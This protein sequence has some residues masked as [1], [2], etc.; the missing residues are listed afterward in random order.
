MTD[1]VE[2]LS[3]LSPEE[4]RALLGRLLRQRA[5]RNE[6]FYPLSHVQRTM[7]IQGQLQAEIAVF[8]VPFAAR[9]RTEMDEA[10]LHRAIAALMDR[11]SVL[12]TTYETQQGQPVQ[13]VH[14]SLAVPLQIWEAAAWSEAELNQRMNEEFHRPFDLQRGPVFRVA[15][16]RR[17]AREH[18]LLLTVH[19]IAVDFWSLEILVDELRSL[20][21]AEKR[22]RP[23]T[24]TPAGRQ[25]TDFVAW[26]AELTA[27][28]EGERLWLYWKEKLAGEL[29]VLELPTDRPRPHLRTFGGATHRFNLDAG[30]Y[31]RVK[32][33]AAGRGATPYVSFLAAFQ[34]LLGRMT[35]QEHFLIGAPTSG[36]NR[37]EF[38]GTVGCLADGV[39]VRADLTG[40]PTFAD[41]LGRVRE[42]VL[43]A[44][45]HQDF[46]SALLVERLHAP[47]DPS[48]SQITQV[49]FGW[50]KPMRLEFQANGADDWLPLEGLLQ[51]TLALRY[52]V[53]LA[54]LMVI[55]LETGTSLSFLYQY[56]TDLF[57]ADTI[58]RMAEH[59]QVLLEAI[60]ADP[61]QRIGQLPILTRTEEQQLL[62]DWNAT[63]TD[64]PE[65]RCVHQLIEDQT[66]RT[67]DS[68][69]VVHGDR[70]LTYRELDEAANCF[71]R[72]LASL[73]VGPEVLA[74]ICVERS[75]EMVIGLLAILKA[76]GAYVPLDPGSPPERL[77]FMIE[78]ARLPVVLTAQHLAGKLPQQSVRLV[79]LDKT[80]EFADQNGKTP[81]S[82]VRPHN[83][84][85]V[86]YTS[87]STGQPK[88]VLIEHRSAV[89]LITS[90]VHSY[91]PGPDDRIL[92]QTALSFDVSVGEI[93]PMLTVGGTVVLLDAAGSQDIDG[94]VACIARHRVTILGAVPS[95]L[96][97]LNE[98]KAEVPSIRLVLSGAEALTFGDIDHLADFAVVTNGYG[99]TET[100]VCATFYR[101]PQ[102]RSSVPRNRVPIGRPI[103]NT[104]IYIL[105]K[106][107][108]PVPIGVA[109]EL[110]IGG[111]GV[112][113]GYLNQPELTAQRF[114]ANPF[115]RTPGARLYKSGD[116]ARYLSDG[117]IEFLGRMDQQ[118]KVRGFRIELGE[119]EAA[120]GKHPGIRQVVVTVGNDGPGGPRLLAYFAP[121]PGQTVIPGELRSFLRGKLPYYMVPSAFVLLE[122]FPLTAGGKVD[123]RAL[124]P[125]GAERETAYVAP[126]TP[127]EEL[128]AEVWSEVLHVDRIGI[129]DDFLELGGHSLLAVQVVSR[130]RDMFHV[131]LPL[132]TL[133][134]A[135][136]TAHLAAYIES[137]VQTR[138][139]KPT[140]LIVPLADRSQA[141]LSF[142]QQLIWML[143][144]LTPGGMALHIPTAVR[145]KGRL[146]VPIL[147]RALNEVV[148]RHEALRTTFAVVEGAPVQTVHAGQVVSLPIEELGK[149]GGVEQESEL[150]RRMA[151][152][153]ILPFDLSRGPL[154][155]ACV[156]RLGNDHHV[157]L[158]IVHHLVVDGWS[159]VILVRE[160]L[161]LYQSFLAGRP[162]PLPELPIQ[163]VDYCH[164]QRR[165]LQDEM[166]ATHL[167]YWRRQLSDRPPVLRLPSDRAR[168][169]VQTYRGNRHMMFV[170]TALAEQLRALSRCEGATLFM[171]LLAAFKV[172][173]YRHTGQDNILAG[174]PVAGRT[175]RE[176]EGLIGVF[177]NT[178]VLRTDL[179]GDPT[180]RELLGR[181]RQ[182]TLDAHAHQDLPYEVLLRE[183]GPRIGLNAAPL[184]Q[185]M[186]SYQV[187]PAPVPSLPGGLTV[188]ALDIDYPVELFDLT[189]TLNDTD[190]GLTC[191]WSY[192][193]ALFEPEAIQDLAQHFEILLGSILANPDMPISKLA[194][195]T[196][197]ERR[198]LL[199]DWNNTQ[200]DLGSPACIHEVFEAQ[201]VKAPDAVALSVGERQLTYRELNE[202]AN[203]LAHYLCELGVRPDVPVGVMLERSLDTVVAMLGVLKAGGAYLTLDPAWP[204][205][206]I[207]LILADSRAVLV[208]TRDSSSSSHLAAQVVH[209]D[210][211]PFSGDR[212]NLS[213]CAVPSNFAYIMY[214]SGSTGMPKGVMVAHS[215]VVNLCRA[216]A[217]PYQ[218]T[219][220]DRVLQFSSLSFDISVEEIFSTLLNGGTLVIQSHKEVPSAAELERLIERERLTI[221]NLPTAYWHEWAQ[222]RAHGDTPLP[223]SLRLVVV[224]GEAASSRHLEAWR[225]TSRHCAW[226]NT[227]GPTEATVTTTCY[228]P[229]NSCDKECIPLGRPLANVQTYVLDQHLAPVPIGAPGELY[230]GGAGVAR[231]YLNQPELTAE[232][233]L[234]DPFRSEP[235]ARLFKT[236]DMARHRRDGVLEFLGRA[237]QQIK[238]RGFRVEPGEI[239]AVLA[240]HPVVRE[241]VVD[242]R[243]H[244]PGDH[245]LIAY[246]VAKPGYALDPQDLRA[247]MRQTL[248]DFMVPAG[249]VPLAELPMTANGK[250]DRRELRTPDVMVVRPQEMVL[251]R[252]PVERRLAELFAGVLGLD[253]VSIHDSFFDLGGH[254]LLA[255]RLIYEIERAYDVHLPLAALFAAP[256]IAGLASLVAHGK[257]A[258]SPLVLL[259]DGGEEW[260]LFCIHP[261]G[262]QVRSYLPLTT[263]LSPAQP[264]YGIQSRVLTGLDQEHESIAS[265]A[266]DYASLI[267]DRQPTGPVRLLGH[268]LGGVVSVAVAALLEQLGRTVQF[269]ALLD[270]Y[271][272]GSEPTRLTFE[273]LTQLLGQLSTGVLGPSFVPL[274][275]AFAAL[276]SADQQ[277]LL[278]ELADR[279]PREGLELIVE[280]MAKT[281]FGL[282]EKAFRQHLELFAVHETLL[283]GYEP[284]MIRAP[285]FS[286]RALEP[287]A[288]HVQVPTD[289]SKYTTGEVIEEALPCNHFTIVQPPAIEVIA[290]RLADLLASDNY[291]ADFAKR[292]MP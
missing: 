146:D 216:V 134:E 292:G 64:F 219:A 172:L 45:T 129:H 170:P 132:Q 55:V 154:L 113:R 266:D 276:S 290:R 155:R 104:S 52:P 108:Q 277:R 87:G 245:R 223:R 152:W 20:Y 54:D 119:V 182:C 58:A 121:H 15:L 124:P 274:G 47:W 239:E 205:E 2:A 33:L 271:L 227:Y 39:V 95:L 107:L 106:H 42:T 67:P 37:A 12:R 270:A 257:P 159:I 84:A 10:A 125:A 69:A 244:T 195:I 112:A 180:F 46:P 1:Q 224:G 263:L 38:A 241:S 92:Q 130:L 93:F 291:V 26:Q 169:A 4:K 149:L 6:G 176:V 137:A 192:N 72:R 127:I 287:L 220:A 259:R 25:Y 207:N 61:E 267:N 3:R 77:A 100:T 196:E 36:R 143:D 89:N 254:S 94:L 204:A 235:G 203:L 96:A 179:A 278:R 262:G 162:S 185:V 184:F 65:N 186:F 109:G 17:T 99:P 73:G 51:E 233:F 14:A 166:L 280:L 222:A 269:V 83:L 260:P 133:L 66:R 206:R 28:P 181:V 8:G 145:I 144:Q 98:R 211:I 208:L 23:N 183:L 163:Y 161:L 188:E 253:Q 70:S 174:T 226:M 136:T 190:R 138:Q 71:A 63:R 31:A 139:G 75:L 281:S 103:A 256:T 111:A 9:I 79:Y 215:S 115:D 13:H 187:Q 268:S 193:A 142:A 202:R 273:S 157:V 68:V 230:I 32:A 11:H 272:P 50:D 286:W 18:I 282:P 191:D 251:P 140:P 56:N 218:L 234:P 105:D 232:K 123:L 43:E 117:N 29:P 110:H 81:T 122:A 102:Q 118:V 240:R 35:G 21:A 250:I 120:L 160:M 148:R 126:R 175:R 210:R 90:F 88:G 200:T 5:H 246:V 167:Q 247:F 275:N 288:G 60:V 225:R 189:V 49:M 213:N 284:P 237:D 41:F 165:L 40:N 198:Q 264:I 228:S 7:W 57:D 231:G 34:V 24:L 156:F 76:G 197:A 116:R 221:L 217:I 236:G 19:H 173:L 279:S 78:D 194:V 27:G 242:L 265:M 258:A 289:W 97:R 212:S 158:L 255:V 131:D 248:P 101:I 151:H 74:G 91:R 135:P 164:W 243:E 86:I 44:L 128:I 249:F 114:I 30:L 283:H 59:Y 177:I 16:F 214:T 53:A 150:R 141:P 153:A 261:A 229:T 22:G 201:A 178:L 80:E 168:P 147:E 82:Q 199:I 238:V 48:H 285:I 171:T 209:L 62:V 252:N 85:Y